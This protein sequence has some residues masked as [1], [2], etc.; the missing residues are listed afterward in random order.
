MK[1]ILA[2]N[3]FIVEIRFY[4]I[5]YSTRLS[6][7]KATNNDIYMKCIDSKEHFLP[8]CVCVNLCGRRGHG[9]WG[10]RQTGEVSIHSGKDKF[11]K[12]CNLLIELKI[13]QL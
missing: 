5:N 10:K 3:M 4:F 13:N 6:C 1:K 11:E 2:R 12:V 7:K 9:I 8:R